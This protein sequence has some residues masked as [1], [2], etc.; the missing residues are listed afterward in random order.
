M[1][2]IGSA[3]VRNK[4]V[5]LDLSDR[6][7]DF[8]VRG[9]LQLFNQP[10]PT[11]QAGRWWDP[12]QFIVELPEV[13]SDDDDGES[14]QRAASST[15]GTGINLPPEFNPTADLTSLEA[16]HSFITK[17]DAQKFKD[18][19][20]QEGGQDQLSQHR[21]RVKVRS[22]VLLGTLVAELFLPKRFRCLGET[23]TLSARYRNAVDL[24]QREPRSLPSCIRHLL[25]RLLLR[26]DNTSFVLNFTDRFP[27]ISDTGLPLPSADQILDS[28][29][30]GCFPAL[31]PSLLHTLNAVESLFKEMTLLP[32]EVHP[33]LAEFQVKLVARRLSLLLQ[34]CPD[35]ELVH[36]AVP[37]YRA[38][39]KDPHTAVQASWL[40]LDP[41]ATNLGPDQTREL[42]LDLILAQ[43]RDSATAKH[44]KLYHRSFVL[45]LIARFRTAVFLD[46]FVN[47]LVEAVGG[48][49]DFLDNDPRCMNSFITQTLP[50]SAV[51]EPE[52]P[53]AN[54]V[55][56][57]IFSFDAWD[58][59]VPCSKSAAGMDHN[60]IASVA[61]NLVAMPAVDVHAPVVISLPEQSS[62]QQA[63]SLVHLENSV[64]QISKESL[65]WLANR[66]GP[67]L[68]A[69]HLSKNLLRMLNLC[70]LPPEGLEA[71][72]LLFPDQ[73]IRLSP[74]MVAGRQ[75]FFFSTLRLPLQNDTIATHGHA[76]FETGIAASAF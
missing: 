55:D 76:G 37:L 52:P 58:S 67:V 22:M 72:S 45:V 46:N 33:I 8:R 60:I 10:H 5:C 74:S 23:A 29:L 38:L 50:S 65:L 51:V 19:D 15:G 17:C 18:R 40:L 68:T 12:R 66:L 73:Q 42:F 24:L 41:V 59:L 39:L 7:K 54:S 44:I 36:L 49:K 53:P 3:A 63:K 61:Q 57:E 75:P 70:F 31:F 16:V 56:G 30:G 11:S 13:D 32:E 27:A 1:F 9:V 47:I 69:R 6:N 35:E 34:H 20:E 48:H 4:N 21:Q 28:L 25:T 43:Y 26:P 14:G 2:F 71:T 62:P 64:V